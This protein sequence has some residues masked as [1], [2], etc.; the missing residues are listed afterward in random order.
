MTEIRC[1]LENSG[2]RNCILL[3]SWQ[4]GNHNSNYVGCI[5]IV[6]QVMSVE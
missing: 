5:L 3:C 4:R 1:A 2:R 6:I